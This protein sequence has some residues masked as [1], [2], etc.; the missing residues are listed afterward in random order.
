MSLGAKQERFSTSLADLIL[1][2]DA[3]NIG[4][5]LKEAW[6]SPETAKIYA[7]KGK[8]IANSNHCKSIAADLILSVNGSVVWDGPAYEKAGSYWLSLSP[9]HSWGGNFTRRDV[10]HF[11]IEHEGVQ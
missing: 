10:Y 6:R 11:S 3:E 4:V 8:G 7:E 9:D 1:Y 2:L 5:R